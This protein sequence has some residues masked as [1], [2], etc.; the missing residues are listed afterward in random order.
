MYLCS[1]KNAS[2]SLSNKNHSYSNTIQLCLQCTLYIDFDIK[3]IKNTTYCIK[4]L[5]VLDLI[6]GEELLLCLVL[7]GCSDL[8]RQSEQVDKALGIVLVVNL[9]LVKGSDLL[10]V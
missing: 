6:R 10:A 2:L 8:Q 7:H 9:I 1:L 4:I 3:N 5:R